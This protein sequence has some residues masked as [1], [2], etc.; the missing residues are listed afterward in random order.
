[1]HEYVTSDKKVKK[2][3]SV[4]TLDTAKLADGLRL[5]STDGVLPACRA[6][7]AD[8]RTDGNRNKETLDEFAAALLQIAKE[9]HSEPDLES[10]H[11]P[12]RLRCVVSTR[13]KPRVIPV[14]AGCHRRSRVAGR[15]GPS[16][17][18]LWRLVIIAGPPSSTKKLL[19]T[20]KVEE[21]D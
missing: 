15:V 3:T 18:S 20:P 4:Q 19:P 10:K 13:P 14:C 21:L 1:M 17:R 6:R 2:E 7:R 16:L 12:I 11:A 8:D 5:S 9:A